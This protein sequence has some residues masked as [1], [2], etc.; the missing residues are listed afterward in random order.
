MLKAILDDSPK[1]FQ[2]EFI[3]MA[4]H[5]ISCYVS[6]FTSKIGVNNSEFYNII[7]TIERQTKYFAHLSNVISIRGG[8]LKKEQMLSGK[9]ADI[10]SNLYLGYSIMWYHRQRNIP[11]NFTKY[12][13]KRINYENSLLFNEILRNLSFYE[14]IFTFQTRETVISP[15]FVEL[16]DVVE[17]LKKDDTILSILKEDVFMKDN[18]LERLDNLRFLE[19]TPEYDLE[20]DKC[21][22][23]GEYKNV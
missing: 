19:N 21:L 13:L 11:E 8:K 6:T 18:V 20:V 14:K 17:L 7:D 23:V 9:M 15:S 4:K 16:N 5:S 10:L 22:Q 12:C 3:K 1:K 2:Q